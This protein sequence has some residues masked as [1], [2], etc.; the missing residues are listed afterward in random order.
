VCVCERERERERER[1]VFLLICEDVFPM[2]IQFSDDSSGI[3]DILGASR[4]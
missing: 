4:Y 2:T 1:V 3:V